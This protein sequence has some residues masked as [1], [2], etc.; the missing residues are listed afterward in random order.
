MSG[1]M[2][3]GPHQGVWFGVSS[4]ECRTGAGDSYLDSALVCVQLS[5]IPHPALCK[6]LYI[7]PGVS[8]P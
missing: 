2:Y 8:H 5:L 3:R 6:V 1:A 7:L 4:L